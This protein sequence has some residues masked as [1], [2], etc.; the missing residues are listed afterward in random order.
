MGFA[1]TDKFPELSKEEQMRIQKRLG[2]ILRST[3]ESYILKKSLHQ[4][5]LR[6]GKPSHYVNSFG[7]RITG[8][9]S[10]LLENFGA[11][12]SHYFSDSSDLQSFLYLPYVVQDA[13]G[14]VRIICE[15]MDLIFDDPNL[16]RRGYLVHYL[17]HLQLKERLA[18]AKWL[19]LVESDQPPR[20]LTRILWKGLALNR[21]A[22]SDQQLFNSFAESHPEYLD[23][24]FRSDDPQSPVHWFYRQVIPFYRSLAELESKIGQQDTGLNQWINLFKLGF[25]TVKAESQGLGLPVRWKIMSTREVVPLLM[26][27]DMHHLVPSAALTYPPESTVKDLFFQS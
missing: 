23:E 18:W 12:P 13:Q 27:Y 4:K 7:Q 2:I 9:F 22:G 5:L 14:N 24:I 20:I 25:L 1:L 17:Y 21:M 3:S 16:E 19:K 11:L 8:Q 6:Y 15:A 26:P 10:D